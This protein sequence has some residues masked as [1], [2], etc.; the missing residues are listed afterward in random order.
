MTDGKGADIVIECVGVPATVSQMLNLVKRGGR[1]VLAGAP[2]KPVEMNFLP[3]W[4]GEVELVAAHATAWQFPRAM[5]LIENGLVD[6]VAALE[7]V[8]P[9]SEGVIALEEAYKSNEIG[10]L[11]IQHNG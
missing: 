8:V 2:V 5:K 11:V 9:F 4:Y 1:C 3:L 10:K 7:R 6:V